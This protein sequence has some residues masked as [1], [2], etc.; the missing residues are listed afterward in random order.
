ME[1]W[2][3]KCLPVCFVCMTVRPYPSEARAGQCPTPRRQPPKLEARF[4]V[5]DKFW[6]GRE[7]YDLD[8]GDFSVWHPNKALGPLY[9]SNLHNDS[10]F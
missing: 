3:H 9:E 6:T 7:I 8:V 5:S 4:A 2:N 1:G 10:F